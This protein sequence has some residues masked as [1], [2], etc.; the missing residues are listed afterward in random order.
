MVGLRL[1]REAGCPIVV[2]MNKIDLV[3]DVGAGEIG[4]DGERLP[5]RGHPGR[6]AGDALADLGLRKGGA[7]EADRDEPSAQRESAIHMQ[8][9]AFGEHGYKDTKT[10]VHLH[11]A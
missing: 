9:T 2:A 7:Q 8:R 6:D 1:A 10:P 11:I 3:D 5:L 4:A